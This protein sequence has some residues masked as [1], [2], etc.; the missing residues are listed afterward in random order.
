MAH[1]GLKAAELIAHPGFK[2]LA[3]KIPVADEGHAEV[4]KGR[5]GGPFKLWY[6]IHGKGS[7]RIVVSRGSASYDNRI[8]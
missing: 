4:A 7:T 8:F 3:W 6:Q 2:H 5:S 1:H